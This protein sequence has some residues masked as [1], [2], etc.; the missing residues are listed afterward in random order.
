MQCLV[1]FI[2]KINDTTIEFWYKFYRTCCVINV[3]RS[4]AS[5]VHIVIFFFLTKKRSDMV[6]KPTQILQQKTLI[7][8]QKFP[9][10]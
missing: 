9:T 1:L 8:S 5:L 6:V 10:F 7:A 2:S 3:V 4:A